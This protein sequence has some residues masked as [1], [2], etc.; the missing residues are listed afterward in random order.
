MLVLEKERIRRACREL[1]LHIMRNTLY[2]VMLA[3]S[4]SSL[5]SCI[6]NWGRPIRHSD[7]WTLNV[8]ILPRKDSS[9]GRTWP[10]KK[11]CITHL[12][13]LKIKI[14]FT[15]SWL[16][17]IRSAVVQSSMCTTRLYE[18]KRKRKT[19]YYVMW[20]N[21]LLYRERER[22]AATDGVSR[23]F[24]TRKNM[25]SLVSPK[26]AAFAPV[27][28]S[29]L[30][31]RAICH[32]CIAAIYT[33]YIIVYLINPPKPTAPSPPCSLYNTTRVRNTRYGICSGERKQVKSQ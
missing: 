32:L 22:E 26:S 11:R 31:V 17:T 15:I 10:N 3:F 18:K 6:F 14:E 13:L 29:F 21:L 20:C 5:R 4:A 28:L 12:C 7:C 30:S 19:V 25:V 24:D 8:Y 23:E 16:G 9:I 33:V 1:H 2:S 27:Y